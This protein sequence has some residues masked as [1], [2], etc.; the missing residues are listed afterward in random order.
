MTIGPPNSG[1][2]SNSRANLVKRG[3]SNV[4]RVEIFD[5]IFFHGEKNADESGSKMTVLRSLKGLKVEML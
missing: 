2:T 1:M 4:H 3:K 5:L